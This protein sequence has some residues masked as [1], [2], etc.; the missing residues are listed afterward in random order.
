MNLLHSLDRPV[1][2]LLGTLRSISRIIAGIHRNDVANAR[3]TRMRRSVRIARLN[4]FNSC[5]YIEYVTAGI[6]TS[7][8]VSV[9]VHRIE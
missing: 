6:N 8:I 1:C 3:L 5:G 7:N 4:E 2:S 9:F